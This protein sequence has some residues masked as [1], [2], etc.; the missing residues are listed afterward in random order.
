MKLIIKSE[1]YIIIKKHLFKD[2]KENM[3][4]A[5]CEKKGCFRYR[6]VSLF[7]PGDEDFN[8]RTAFR[9][10]LK[11]EAA[12]P[13]LSKLKE[14]GYSFLQIHSHVHDKM[15]FFTRTDNKNNSFNTADIREFNPLATFFRILFTPLK[16]QGEY[17][18]YFFKCFR[19]MKIIIE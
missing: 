6:V 12:Y 7:C 2:K 8:V 16:C 1:N 13:V 10:S 17:F 14:K 19:K 15:L 4:L 9:I 11:A 18:S 3:I 5:L